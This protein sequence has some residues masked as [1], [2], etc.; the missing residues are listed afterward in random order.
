MR[1]PVKKVNHPPKLLINKILQLKPTS[2]QALKKYINYLELSE[3]WSATLETIQDKALMKN[4]K[5]SLND[6]KNGAFEKF[7]F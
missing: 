6:Y 7:E 4:A 3:E 2:Q 1:S 5:E